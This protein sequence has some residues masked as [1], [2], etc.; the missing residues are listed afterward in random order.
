MALLKVGSLQ[1]Q[2]RAGEVVAPAEVKNCGL[3]ER[4]KVKNCKMEHSAYISSAFSVPLRSK[5]LVLSVVDVL[6][7][8]LQHV[9]GRGIVAKGLTHVD[10]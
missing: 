9:R 10:E 1:I 3:L 6:G 2:T 4:A 8:R 7:D 5:M